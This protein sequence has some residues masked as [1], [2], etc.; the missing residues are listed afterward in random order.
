M[1]LSSD[2]IKTTRRWPYEPKEWRASTF[3]WYNGADPNQK[4][5]HKQMTVWE[6]LVQE[7]HA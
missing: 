5:P 6:A 4:I 3:P 1:Y 7:S 2:Y